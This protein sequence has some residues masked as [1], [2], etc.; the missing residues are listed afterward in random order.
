MFHRNLGSPRAW[1]ARR[2]SRGCRPVRR[3]PRRTK[4]RRAVVSCVVEHWVCFLGSFCQ[5]HEFVAR[6]ILRCS[7]L[8]RAILR[9]KK[10]RS[11]SKANPKQEVPDFGS[12]RI[13]VLSRPNHSA[14]QTMRLEGGPFQDSCQQHESTRPPTRLRPHLTSADSCHLRPDLNYPPT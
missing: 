2:P 11:K 9:W 1:C 5:K 3:L 12:A 10:N 8:P 13:S 6:A 14:A 4:K 7:D